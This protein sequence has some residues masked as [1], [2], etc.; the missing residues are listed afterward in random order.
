M[1]IKIV[2]I[3]NRKFGLSFNT[4][5]EI[6]KMIYYFSPSINSEQSFISF[7]E[8]KLKMRHEL[9]TKSTFLITLITNFYITKK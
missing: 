6:K 3:N 8:I 4:E 7:P 5:I 1:I 2:Y 9:L